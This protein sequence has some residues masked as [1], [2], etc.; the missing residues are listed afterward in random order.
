M[1]PLFGLAGPAEA[2]D[3]LALAIGNGGLL[4]LGLTTAVAFVTRSR[5]AAGVALAVAF[6]VTVLFTPWEAFRPYQSDDPDVHSWVATWRT[7]GWWW[8]LAVAATLATTVLAFRYP[9]RPTTPGTE[10]ATPNPNGPE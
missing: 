6:V 5:V 7:F 2:F 10:H 1:S 9:T 4:L 3:A 8:G